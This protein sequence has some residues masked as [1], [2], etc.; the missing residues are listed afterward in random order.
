MEPEPAGNPGPLSAQAHFDSFETPN[1]F[2]SKTE[3]PDA[4]GPH[5]VQIAYPRHQSSTGIWIDTPHRKPRDESLI[6]DM[7]L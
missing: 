7:E 3:S 2:R 5:G 1:P 4:E 6:F